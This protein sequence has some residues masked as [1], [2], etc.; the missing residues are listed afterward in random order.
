MHAETPEAKAGE[1]IDAQLGAAGWA[2]AAPGS[3][4][5]TQPT[6]RGELSGN[7]GRADY[8]LYLDGKVCGIIEAKRADHSLQGVQEQSATYAAFRRWDNP[9]TCW[10]SPLPFR[11]EANG[12]QIQFTDARDPKPRA[13]NL[14]HFPSSSQPPCGRP[15]GVR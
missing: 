12:R 6:A 2:V 4:V 3:Q 15:P 14:F 10:Q 8:V 5:G 7:T 9:T 13:R 1:E 11:F